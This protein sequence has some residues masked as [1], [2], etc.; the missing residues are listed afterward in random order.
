M[1]KAFL[2]QGVETARPSGRSPPGPVLL[3]LEQEAPWG[4]L[5]G[6]RLWRAIPEVSGVG[7]RGVVG[8]G[9]GGKS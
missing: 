7:N 4:G 8:A 1:L 3:V 9:R 5:A 6:T 2:K